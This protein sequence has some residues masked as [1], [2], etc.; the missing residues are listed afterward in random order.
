MDEGCAVTSEADA[1][2][3]LFG[4]AEGVCA[5]P[6]DVVE[7]MRVG[8]QPRFLRQP[9]VEHRLVDLQD[10]GFDERHRFAERGAGLLHLLLHALIPADARVLI[11]DQPGVEGDALEVLGDAVGG[12]ERVGEP[13]R[14]LRER[15]LEGRER[16][17]FPDDLLLGSAPGVVRRIEIG[18]VPLV[19][20]RNFRAVAFLSLDVAR[21]CPERVEGLSGERDERGDEQR[22]QR[23][24]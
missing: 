17:D 15:A 22:Q 23:R 20:V 16:R 12:V 13:L 18:E 11:G 3:A 2:Q 4:V 21:D 10:F 24:E 14:R 7:V 8:A 6:L 1:H 19:A 9:F 5:P